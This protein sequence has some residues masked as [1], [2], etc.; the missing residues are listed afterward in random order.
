MNEWPD[1]SSGFSNLKQVVM[2]MYW[3]KSLLRFDL[4]LFVYIQM[5]MNVP[6]SGVS[7]PTG[8]ATTCSVLTDACATKASDQQQ[9]SLLVK[10][11]NIHLIS[12]I[13]EK[14]KI[15]SRFELSHLT[16]TV[17]EEQFRAYPSVNALIS[18]NERMHF[19]FKQNDFYRD[20]DNYF[21]NI[22]SFYDHNTT[23]MYYR[24]FV[25]EEICRR[26]VGSGGG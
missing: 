23:H 8:N 9:T 12:W 16:I 10:V 15:E 19:I 24:C 20:V 14:K 4:T 3:Y 18:I 7:A 22:L 26:G 2:S 13:L 17:R 1:L 5:W 21:C 6:V 11:R 25:L